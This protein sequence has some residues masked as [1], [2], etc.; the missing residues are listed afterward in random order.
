MKS[1]MWA[2][3]S[4]GDL[5]STI[6]ECKKVWNSFVKRGK[7]KLPQKPSRIL[8]MTEGTFDVEVLEFIDTN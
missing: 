1:P 7:S 3:V 8:G 4:V 2:E 6:G 5:A